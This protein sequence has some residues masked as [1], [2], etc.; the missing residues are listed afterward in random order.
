MPPCS[1]NNL[2]GRKLLQTANPLQT[3]AG[4]VQTL[5]DEANADVADTAVDDAFGRPSPASFDHSCSIEAPYSMWS[6]I[7]STL[8]CVG[9]C[10][11][12]HCTGMC[13]QTVFEFCCYVAPQYTVMHTELS[14]MLQCWCCH[15]CKNTLI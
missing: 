13:G 10:A 5:E 3:T 7:R 9:Q 4:D 2:P 12:E 1:G 15:A 14:S 11:S 8:F 6:M